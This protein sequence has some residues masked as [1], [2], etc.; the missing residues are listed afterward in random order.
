MEANQSSFTKCVSSFFFQYHLIIACAPGLKGLIEVAPLTPKNPKR[1]IFKQIFFQNLVF[2]SF[3][4]L[5][6]T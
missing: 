5:R 6:R 1:Y 3:H 4:I 2:I